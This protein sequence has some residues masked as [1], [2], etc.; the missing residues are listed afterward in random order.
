MVIEHCRRQTLNAAE[1]LFDFVRRDRERLADP[2][3]FRKP[4]WG[5]CVWHDVELEAEHDESASTIK[6]MGRALA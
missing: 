1:F 3:F 4:K 5:L 6:V 2:D